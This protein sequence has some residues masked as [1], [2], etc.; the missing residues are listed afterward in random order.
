MAFN[1]NHFSLENNPTLTPEEEKRASYCEMLDSFE[2]TIHFFS[3]ISI[4]AN[5]PVFLCSGPPHHNTLNTEEG[6]DWV[7]SLGR[8]WGGPAV[9]QKLA[10][11]HIPP[12]PQSDRPPSEGGPVSIRQNQGRKPV[13]GVTGSVMNPVAQSPVSR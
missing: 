9:T 8:S 2:Y 12:S 6:A 11:G 7:G 5:C 1:G 10:T 4:Q 3:Y 13:R